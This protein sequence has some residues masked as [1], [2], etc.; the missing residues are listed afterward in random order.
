MVSADDALK[1]AMRYFDNDVQKESISGFRMALRI[2]ES[3]AVSETAIK[4]VK[5][6]SDYA[7]LKSAVEVAELTAKVAIS[8]AKVAILEANHALKLKD[9]EL[10]MKDKELLQS[11]QSV[12]SR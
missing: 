8:E 11:K 6:E 4:D 12:T 3:K 9:I 10:K 1:E 2:L 7:K 5:T